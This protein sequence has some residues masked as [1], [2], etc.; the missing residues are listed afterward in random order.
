MREVYV[1]FVPSIITIISTIFDTALFCNGYITSEH[2]VKI[3][4]LS[5][6]GRGGGKDGRFSRDIICITSLQKNKRS[7]TQ[8]SLRKVVSGLQLIEENIGPGN[9]V[10]FRS[11]GRA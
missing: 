10:A 6:G 3:T 8:R 7:E 1:D 2:R 9:W 5:T 11:M 4:L